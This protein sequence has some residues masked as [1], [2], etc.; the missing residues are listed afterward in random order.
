MPLSP[1]QQF[2]KATLLLDRGEIERGES[3]LRDAVAAADASGHEVLRIRA[4]CCLGQLLVELGRP[5]E[6]SPLLEMVARH[7]S[8]PNLDD[9]LDFEQQTAEELL[10]RIG[11]RG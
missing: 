1:E 4:R 6:A 9:V 10:R 7:V 11:R 8:S 2:D 3:L 5:D